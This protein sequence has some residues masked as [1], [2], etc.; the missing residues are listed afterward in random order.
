MTKLVLNFFL[1]LI[2]VI[3]RCFLFLQMFNVVIGDDWC[4]VVPQSWINTDKKLCS[5]PSHINMSKAVRKLLRPQASWDSVPYLLGPYNKNN[6][7]N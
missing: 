3:L 4:S 2:I 1:F 5:W 6:N 7:K